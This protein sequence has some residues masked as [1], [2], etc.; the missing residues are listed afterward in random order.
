MMDCFM[1]GTLLAGFGLVWMLVNWC[2]RQVDSQESRRVGVEQDAS[3]RND[4]FP[5]GRVSSIRLG[6]SGA[7]LIS[8]TRYRRSFI[9]CSWL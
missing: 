5:A 4:W 6:A 8:K 2:Q 1:A 9:C 3:A 7:I